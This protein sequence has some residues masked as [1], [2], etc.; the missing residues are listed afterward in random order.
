M[1]SKLFKVFAV[2]M[3]FALITP[4][5]F[6][7]AQADGPNLPEVNRP[8]LEELEALEIPS[9]TGRYVLVLEGNSLLEET[10]SVEEGISIQGQSY[11]QTLA[12]KR[13]QTL[14]KLEAKLGRSLSVLQVYD[15]LV[16]GVSVE[17][18][19]L[20]AAK[21]EAMP[22]VRK[23]FPV[24]LEQPVTDAGPEWIGANALW[25]GTAVPATVG[26]QGEGVLVGIIDTGINFD[27]PS[28]SDQPAD[29]F[30]YE[31]EGDY[32]GVCAPDGDPAY[33]DACNDKLV[34]AYSYTQ[35]YEA[36]TPEDAN[37]HGSHTASTVAGNLVEMDYFGITQ[38]ITGVAPHAQIVSYDVCIPSGCYSDWS[39]AAIEQ[40][41]ID[42]VDVINYSIS[43][44]E[45][46]E[47]DLVEYWF[48]V[49]TQ[50]GLTVST[51]AGNNGPDAGTVAH[52]SPWVL[53]TAATTHDRKFV[54]SV[55]DFSHPEYTNI[56]T[57]LGSIPFAEAVVDS[58][59][60]YA[61]EDDGNEL[62]CVPFPAD[63]FADS[64]ALIKRGGCT[65]DV[66]VDNAEAAGA[67]GVLIFT[68]TAAPGGLGGVTATIP[69]VMLAVDGTTGQAIA[70]W[71]AGETDETVS[72]SAFYKEIDDS[73]ADIMAEFSSRGPNTT[74]DVLKPDLGAPG[75]E[76]L[77]AYADGTIAPD[78]VGDYTLMSGTSM[79]SP[80]A[81]GS[82]AL[83][84][85]LHPDWSPSE[86][87]SALMLTAFEEVTNEVAIALNN[88]VTQPEADPF[89]I[90]AGR[91]QL[92]K[93]G[94]VGLVMD[95]SIGNYYNA[96]YGEGVDVRDLNIPSLQNSE[97]VNNC[98]WTRTFTSVADWPAHYEVDAPGWITVQPDNFVV[99]PGETQEIT[100][101]ADVEGLPLN[102][103]QY[104]S[105]HFLAD[106]TFVSGDPISDVHIPLAVLPSASNIPGKVT[107]ETHRDADGALVEDLTAVE[108]TAGTVDVSG[109]FK[110]EL[111]EFVL[112]S[113]PTNDTG[114]QID[115]LDQV[116]VKKIVVPAY[117]IRLVAEI[118]ETTS[119]DLD[120]FLYWDA[121]GSEEFDEPDFDW[122]IASSAAGGSM[123]YIEGPKDWIYWYE[124]D[125]YFLVVQNWQ[126]GRAGDSVTLATGIV[127]Y[128]DDQINMEVVIPEEQDAGDPFDMEITW[129]VDTEESDRLYGYF[130]TC[131]DAECATY[132]GFTDIDIRRGV[133]DV[134]KSVD[135]ESA[136]AGDTVTYTIDVTNFKDEPIT[137]TID[138]E[139][140]ELVEYV[141]GSVTNA[142]YDAIDNAIVFEDEIAKGGTVAITFQATV[143]DVDPETII[144]NIAL[145]DGNGLGMA[146]EE[147]LPVSFIAEDELP[148]ALDKD[149]TTNEDVSLFFSLT[150]TGLLPGPKT[151]TILTEPMNGKLTGDAP[152]LTYTPDPDWYG[153][154]S[155]TFM[156]N[157]GLND[158]NVGTIEIEVISV[159]DAPEANA[160]DYWTDFETQLV[161]SAE[162]GV[163]ANDGDP[164]P[165]DDL[166]VDLKTD[167]AYGTLDLLPDGSFTYT[168]DDDFRG[169]D[170]FV[171]TLYGIPAPTD[172][173]TMDATVTI[174]VND[175]P[176]ADAQSVETDEDT[177]L[178]VTLTGDF[179]EP[180]DVS[181]ILIDED[182]EIAG[183][184]TVEGGL[185]VAGPGTDEVT[186][187]PPA[188]WFGTDSFDFKVDDGLN[189]SEVATITIDVL[190]I[191]DA[192]VA[193]DDAYETD[194]DTTLTVAAPGVLAND[195]D[196]EDDPL[197]VVLGT[198]DVENGTLTLNADGS[199]TYEP[200]ED[201]NGTD[202]FSYIVSD[203]SID[204]ALDDEAT[205]TITVTAVNDA[206]V[207][208]DDA[209]EM[210]EDTTITYYKANPDSLI[211]NDDDVDGDPLTYILDVDVEHGALTLWPAGG[212]KYTP[213]AD[214][215]GTD[216]FTYIANDGELDSNI[217][218]VTITI[219]PVNDA[220]VAEDDD[221]HTPEETELVVSAAEGILANDSDIDGDAL[222]FELGDLPD[223]GVLDMN[224]DGSFSYEPLLGFRGTDTFT[225]ILSDGL[226]TDTA[227]VTIV[228]NDVP[229]ALDAEYETVEDTPLAITLTQDPAFSDPGPATWKVIDA[230]VVTPGIQTAQGGTITYTTLPSLTYTPAMNFVGTD[231]FEFTVNDGLNES[232]PGTI[233]IEVTPVNDSPQ[234]NDDFYYVDA[235]DT[236]VVPA[237]GVLENDIE[238]DD[239]TVYVQLA[240]EPTK[241]TLT[242]NS[243]GSFIY[244]PDATNPYGEVT[245]TYTMFGVPQP[246]DAYSDTATVTITIDDWPE[247]VDDEYETGQSPDTLIVDELDG[248]LANDIDP[249]PENDDG[250]TV[251]TEPV[252]DPDGTV[253]L[254]ED[255]SFE[256]TPD[257]DFRGYDSFVYEVQEPDSDLTD[258]GTVTILVN[259][260]PTAYDASLETPEETPIDID[261]EDYANWIPYMP[262][263]GSEDPTTWTIVAQPEHGTLAGTAPELTYTPDLNYVGEDEFTFI[264]NDGLS[265]SNE[266]TITIT[267]TPVNDPSEAE[268]D[269]YET[270][271][272][273]EL[274]VTAED[275]VMAND[276]D[277]DDDPLVVSLVTDVAYGTLDLNADGSFTYMPDA[278]F[279]GEDS[280]VYE[281]YSLADGTTDPF[282]SDQATVIITVTPV[283]DAPVAEDVS[284]TT[285]EDTPVDVTLVASDVDDD[286]LTYAI[287]DEPAHGSV[288][289]V[290]DVATYTPEL[291]FTGEDSFTFKAND[292]T[293]DSNVAT[294]TITVTPVN[295]APV[296]VDDE[297]TVAE[298][299]TLTISVPGVL[300][301]DSD[302]EGDTLTAILVDTVQNG[303]LTLNADGS[304]IYTPNE[305]FNGT[306]SFTYKASDGELESELAV[307]TITVTPVNDWP[308]ANDDYY[309]VV[310]GTELVKDAAEGI[311]ANDVLLD[312]DEEVS[313][314]IL[315]E[316]QHGALSMND[317]GSFTYTPNPGYMGTDT[318]RY[319]VLSVQTINAA[320]W[321]D[322]A[323]VT[324][325]VQPLMRLFLPLILR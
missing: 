282:Y 263:V 239:D 119:P 253:I 10:G 177:D 2:V 34:G 309:E 258:E 18:S 190:P 268:D 45:D 139:L 286:T 155:F 221:Y 98:S 107:F 180:G 238:Y 147:T 199:F 259:D 22:E 97:C 306:D 134:I 104:A 164:D 90:G 260:K 283:N 32:L 184:Q 213:D 9:E 148:V 66:K 72:I 267:M 17:L 271:E 317:D 201:W 48:L 103:W 235:D 67:T 202:T 320:E 301:N 15:V 58:A 172:T 56:D 153:T 299:E 313:I 151:W 256:Y 41:V 228:V 196:V 78:S 95:E 114:E 170:Q 207:A 293:A 242:F 157:D 294:V 49:A 55:V 6:V 290:G 254:Y 159:K 181:W 325:T 12:V 52:R 251:N 161:V 1:R 191:N 232:E 42:G 248:L 133:D 145:H 82:A 79:S 124:E 62:G 315:E 231:S 269:A 91:I 189:E 80:H 264:V 77:A 296:A 291:D 61:G 262:E 168:P 113:D 165:E 227:T 50:A 192:P 112:A 216:T 197:S 118:V 86:I 245:F 138:D 208:G 285:E 261:L 288:I 237:P 149:L 210:D 275:G 243:N 319:M 241:G 125:T 47:N 102:V 223:N 266:G 31:W 5:V 132:L 234:A 27:H 292:G 307:V 69:N 144:T 54:D 224:A 71:V 217:A 289:L 160:D 305:Y 75:V 295:D 122:L 215:N 68:T 211:V 60:V 84:K 44:G 127:P 137:Y 183:I 14:D 143:D 236:L 106:S 131:A 178:V 277:P 321:S 156:V 250:L 176:V 57:Y 193:M 130:E 150:G 135:V 146:P 222:T 21:I 214:F 219:N 105:I 24:T 83:L 265:D 212:F 166:Y 220:P 43:G 278:D 287:V 39:A 247:A 20:E 273:T 85:A 311:L 169:L 158:S 136:V 74:F 182:D 195:E 63:F 322:D 25:D 198:N 121:N 186:Y 88:Q 204:P 65:F 128:D 7:Q 51:S 310:T 126:P 94:L 110:A 87:Q 89:D 318:F 29:L 8:E 188:D 225:Y 123:E 270:P 244:E 96:V 162:D 194:E 142:E 11:L 209:Y 185:V 312:P 316:P 100:V 70:N 246:A 255:G 163:M 240:S 152:D 314:Q 302:V 23:V 64:I 101:T 40:A 324:I 76:I 174:T 28:F 141:V 111:E 35:G 33:A 218:T 26:S 230:D 81:A 272:D 323:T 93:A 73:N 4:S 249:D 229:V 167:V 59:I 173:T 38:L 203:G 92:E 300:G 117:S 274:V 206:P 30:D 120:M 46:P 129:D 37:G 233:T 200:D 187:T 154:D 252:E 281:L 280:F 109:L 36:L 226:L 308:I 53:S 115:D 279:N 304:F 303:T 175:I 205:V 108:I 284:E 99:N 140:P 3:L 19:P 13:E 257:A 171:Y 116:F 298:K 16:H 276:S 297:Y 179:L